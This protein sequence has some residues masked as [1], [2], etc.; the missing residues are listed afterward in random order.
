MKKGRIYVCHTFYH[1]YIAFL[2]EFA[3]ARVNSAQAGNATLV[4]SLMSNDWAGLKERAAKSGVF[5][6][7]LEFD[8]KRETEFPEL[9]KYKINRGNILFNMPQRIRFTKKFAKMQERFVPVD[10]KEYDEVYV[11]CDTDP[12]GLYLNQ[13][14]VHYHSVEDGLN[15]LSRGIPAKRD[16]KSFFGLKKFMSMGLNLI[17]MQDGYSKYCIDM[18]VN[19]LSLVDDDLYKYRELPRKEL[20]DALTKEQ[21]D[22]L[23][24]AFVRDIDRMMAEVGNA[25]GG[26]D[27]ILILTEPLCKDLNMRE[28]LFRDLVNEYSAEGT[29]F[30]KIHPRDELDYEKLF[31]D[32]F[33]FDK[34]VPMEILNFF[35]EIR[36]KKVV[37][38]FT[39]LGSINYADEKVYLGKKFMDKYEDPSI[40]AHIKE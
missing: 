9:A 17:F 12:I 27:N 1:A 2:K 15:Y 14:K 6:E 31:S 3:I 33:R 39:Q 40:H 35:S 10:F 36:F 24:R 23:I 26:K 4:L 34:T 11:F 37:A 21:K 19:D 29:V 38:I 7:V 8:E 28:K 32:V 25:T 20:E 5:K 30:L 22:T 18:E 13:K 16:N